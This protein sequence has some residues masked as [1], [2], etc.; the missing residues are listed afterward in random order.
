MRERKGE[1]KWKR[2]KE[3]MEARN[4]AKERENDKMEIENGRRKV[5][6][7]EGKR[8][9]EQMVESNRGKG[10]KEEE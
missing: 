10:R 9:R 4:R 5:C 3:R 7:R 2:E 1:N 6:E 8:I